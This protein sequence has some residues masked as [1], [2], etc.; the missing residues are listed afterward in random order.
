LRHH[1]ALFSGSRSFLPNGS[2]IV[3]FVIYLLGLSAPISAQNPSYPGT[4]ITGQHRLAMVRV[5]FQPDTSNLTTGTGE[6]NLEPTETFADSIIDPPPHNA[7]YFLDQTKALHNYFFRV[8]GQRLIIDTVTSDIFPAGETSTYTL[9]YPMEDYGKG[10]ADSTQQKNWAD[11]L[12]DTYQLSKN[13]I[14]DFGQY[15]TLVIFHAGVGQDFDIPLDDTPYDIQS[16]YLDREFIETHFTGTQLSELQ[17]A[18]IE[19]VIILPETQSQLEISIGLTGT[20]ALLFGTRIGLPAMYNTN[21]GQS[22]AGKFGL[23]D[24][25]SNNANG[26]APA[27]PSAWTRLFAGWA[28]AFLARNSGTYT[29]QSAEANGNAPEI[30]KVPINTSEYYLIENRLRQTRVSSLDS[31][32]VNYDTLFVQR[33]PDT[34]VITNVEEY[35]AGLPGDGLLIWHVDE[36]V[37]RANLGSNTINTDPD[38]RGVDLEE[39]DGAQDIGEYYGDFSGGIEN[40]WYFDMWFAKNDGFFHLNPDYET[41]AD[42]TIGFGTATFPA[43]FTN[44]GAYTGISIIKIPEA[45]SAVQI[46]ITFNRKIPGFPVQCSGEAAD[47]LL[48]IPGLPSNYLVNVVSNSGEADS[49]WLSTWSGD[50]ISTNRFLTLGNGSDE[51][52]IES[53][54]G[55]INA[56]NQLVVGTLSRASSSISIDSSRVSEYTI[57]NDG[58]VISRHLGTFSGNPTTQ[59]IDDT[60]GYIFATS[61]QQVRKLHRTGTVDWSVLIPDSINSLTVNTSTEVFVGTQSGLYRI[62]TD[63]S[64]TLQDSGAYRTVMSSG[65]SGIFGQ[66]EEKL[67]VAA[68]ANDHDFF[69]SDPERPEYTEVLA[70][71]VDGDGANEILSLTRQNDEWSIIAYNDNSSVANN[72]P[73]ELPGRYTAQNIAVA[74]VN[75]DDLPEMFAATDSGQIYAFDTHGTLLPNF[76]IDVGAQVRSPLS[77]VNFQGRAGLVVSDTSGVVHGF[78]VFTDP[79]IQ[80]GRVI[81]N[82]RHGNPANSRLVSAPATSITPAGKPLIRRAYIYPNPVRTDNATLR[83]EVNTGAEIRIRI[84]DFSGRNIQEW[85]L[86]ISSDESVYDVPWNTSNI[87]SGVYFAEVRVTDGSS[88]EV[89]IVKIARVR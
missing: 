9:P 78:Y 63:Q 22:V 13:D 39:A 66:K 77:V 76:P 47:K 15:S 60:T 69:P 65:N 54:T 70:A 24:L 83:I 53:I 57:S 14:G 88:E 87:P 25:G 7:A 11:L 37:I 18:G 29:V 67:S 33:S 51:E 4:P 3:G 80:F 23:M 55:R 52:Q 12:Y 2:L 1:G 62:G 61:E 81:W 49:L 27:Y 10:F 6:F 75:G 86:G 58:S 84:F 43:T 5:E 8:S 21:N 74:D 59:L 40:G 20:Y 16:A 50:T 48:S 45:D 68:S 41:D 72:F 34:H 73:L 44:S 31:F 46:E 38:R 32:M 82:G 85:E 42:S 30:L 26:I 56:Q 36:S 35:D 71:D 19:H 79:D 89:K 64:V 28:Q 17:N